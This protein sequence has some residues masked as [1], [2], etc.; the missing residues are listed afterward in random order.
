[1]AFVFLLE[2][3]WLDFHVVLGYEPIVA[4]TGSREP[5][6][7]SEEGVRATATTSEEG[8]LK[9]V[10]GGGLGPSGGVGMFRTQC[11]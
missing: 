6:F 2:L 7:D 9:C 3:C 8:S 4:T 11:F 1:M 10:V 5:H